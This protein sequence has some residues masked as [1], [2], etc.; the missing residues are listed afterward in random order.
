MIWAIG[1][2]IGWCIV[3]PWIWKWIEPQLDRWMR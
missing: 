1:I 2:L 3:G